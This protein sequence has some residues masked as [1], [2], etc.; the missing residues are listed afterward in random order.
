MR[1]ELFSVGKTLKGFP[2]TQPV[3]WRGRYNSVAFF[4]GHDDKRNLRGRK[5]RQITRV[6]N[7]YIVS[8]ISASFMPRRPISGGLRRDDTPVR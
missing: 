6:P 2:H 5:A 8:M 7:A 3:D 4:S 1:I